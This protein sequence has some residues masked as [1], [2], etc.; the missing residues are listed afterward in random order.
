MTVRDG[1]RTTGAGDGGPSGQG[2][3]LRSWGTRL[4][5]AAVVVILI[6]LIRPSILRQTLGSVRAVLIV[7]A[8]IAGWVVLG[9]VLQ[10]AVPNAYVRNAIL[11]LPGLAL[12]WFLIAPFFLG[13]TVVEAL[14]G[15]PA[16]GTT[17]GTTA[18]TGG[19]TGSTDGGTAPATGT[20]GGTTGAT[21]EQPAA[22][23]ELT[24]LG[25]GEIAGINHRAS[26]TA[27]LYRLADG[28]TLIRLEDIDISPG[29]DYDVYLVPEANAQSPGSG[30]KIDDLKGNKG[31]Q[32]YPVPPEL[33]V[34]G[35]QTVLIWC[36]SFAVPIAAAPIS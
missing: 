36:T 2:S 22:A 3:R 5:I 7:S 35:P 20:D 26:G 19:S 21:G 27:V 4:G 16:T 14:P 32:N 11:V 23:P 31:S 1:T 13:T 33:S 15:A 9:R 29:P 17:A 18:G 8:I 34:E 28:S 12:G 30:V 10:R 6:L 24:E 25:R